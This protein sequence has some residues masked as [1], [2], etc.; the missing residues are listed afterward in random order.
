L[1]TSYNLWRGKGVGLFSK[2]KQSKKK[3]NIKRISGE[4]YDVNKQMPYTV[5]KS[6]NESRV[7][8]S[9]QHTQGWLTIC[10]QMFK[11]I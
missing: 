6:T 1:V 2:E 5:P 11:K 4:A 7:Q 10:I 3:V 8:Y 9:L